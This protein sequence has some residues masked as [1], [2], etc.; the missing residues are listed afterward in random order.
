MPKNINLCWEFASYGQTL[1][2]MNITQRLGRSNQCYRAC[3][4][5]W[6]RTVNTKVRND[7]KIL[8]GKLSQNIIRAVKQQVGRSVFETVALLQSDRER[9]L[10]T[11]RLSVH[12]LVFGV[13]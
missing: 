9:Q 11:A 13:K 10:N 7:G 1:R 4:L 5:H 12:M 6:P 3:L 2:K 8:F